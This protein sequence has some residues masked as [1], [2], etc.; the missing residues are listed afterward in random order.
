MYD[1]ERGEWCPGGQTPALTLAKPYSS[2]YP[3]VD[4]AGWP[5]LKRYLEGRELDPSLALFNGWYPSKTAGDEFARVVI[6][7]FSTVPE[8]MYWQARGMEAVTIRY[9][10]PHG[11]QR[12]D[13]IVRVIPHEGRPK[14]TVVVEGPMDALAA[15]GAG[16]V[17]VALMGAVPPVDAIRT[18]F[19]VAVGTRVLV[20]ADEGALGAFT[21][22]WRHF[23]GAELR[24]TYPFKDLAE[25]PKKER[26][27]YLA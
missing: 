17:G 13:A 1:H 26:G 15:A 10:S 11:C 4:N 9:Q 12:G 27:K 14:G 20:V 5:L 18:A 25:V 6:P 7:C 16:F 8:N 19:D 21:A 24:T 2:S 23:P 22:V 3:E